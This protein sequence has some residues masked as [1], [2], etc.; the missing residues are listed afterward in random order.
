MKRNAA[1]VIKR[2]KPNDLFEHFVFVGTIR[3]VNFILALTVIV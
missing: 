1:D 3:N 2:R